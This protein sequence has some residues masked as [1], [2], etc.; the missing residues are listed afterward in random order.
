MKTLF[1]LTV[2]AAM[3]LLAGC[4]MA[5]APVRGGVAMDVRGPVAMGDDS[6]AATKVGVAQAE[7]ILLFSWGDA[8]IE[9][10]RKSVSPAILRIHHVDSQS[11]NILG[12]YSRYTT[13]VYG[14]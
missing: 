9:A 3:T 11:T 5:R 12:I 7:G 4:T 1:C 14:Q 6:A 8:S 10:A 13:I 2:L